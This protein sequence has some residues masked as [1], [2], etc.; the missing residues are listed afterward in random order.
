MTRT[1]SRNNI[2]PHLLQSG[3]PISTA[4]FP[5]NRIIRVTYLTEPEALRA[6]LPE[7]IS[8]VGEPLVSFM[9]RF[10]N[11]LDWV[12]NGELCAIGMSVTARYQGAQDTAQGAY[13]PALWENDALAVILGRE[14]FGVPK[15]YADISNPYC[16][17]GCW[18]ALLSDAGRPLIEIK[19]EQ[20]EAMSADD[21]EQLNTQAANAHVL[22]WKV[23]P[24]TNGLDTE[25]SYA[26]HFHSPNTFEQAW[27]GSGSVEIFDVDPTVN[28]WHGPVIQALRTL[29]L[30]ECVEATMTVGTGEHR[31]SEGIVL[32]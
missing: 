3:E 32:R 6:M 31:V 30:I 24:T 18:R 11:N 2:M 5:Y 23:M 21:L 4:Y 15:M 25:L 9:Y 28:F 13:W 19:Y 16:S 27:R 12:T 20:G 8:Y 22:G 10:S 29:P 7:N 17:K 14:I 26:T 1:F